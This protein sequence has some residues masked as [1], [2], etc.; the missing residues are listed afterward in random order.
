[1][2]NKEI[3]DPPTAIAENI[4]PDNAGFKIQ[5][6]I[7][8]ARSPIRT[9]SN[10]EYTKEEAEW[11]VEASLNYIDLDPDL[12]KKEL[13]KDEFEVEVPTNSEGKVSENDAFDAYTELKALMEAAPYS[14]IEKL[15]AVDV[16][17][18]TV[19]GVVTF[20]T[21]R[22][23]GKVDQQA[24]NIFLNTDYSTSARVRHDVTEHGSINS[25]GGGRIDQEL[26][27]RVNWSFGFQ[28]PNDILTD[29]ETWSILGTGSNGAS[30]TPDLD[31]HILVHTMFPNPN[32]PDGVPPV[33]YNNMDYNDYLLYY[34]PPSLPS[35][36]I[37]ETEPCLT[38]IAQSFLTQ[39]LHDVVY[40]IKQDYV[41]NQNLVPVSVSVLGWIAPVTSEFG[42]GWRYFHDVQIV[43]GRWQHG[44]PCP[45]PC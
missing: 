35:T 15:V 12:I 11:I 38:P 45:E 4:A 34:T 20:R 43:Y 44:T 39:G 37:I 30:Q 25:C 28:L 42:P 17:A 5:A 10:I 22:V 32:D 16:V 29:I 23:V 6:F 40:R 18:K 1:M 36:N 26:M 3:H 19:N 21:Y 8:K 33:T 9:K 31:N 2:C 27:R 13:R 14:S 7:E 41:Q 24:L